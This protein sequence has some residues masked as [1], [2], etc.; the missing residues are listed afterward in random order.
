VES[1]TCSFDSTQINVHSRASRWVQSPFVSESESQYGHHKY[2]NETE[3]NR[4]TDLHNYRYWQALIGSWSMAV[5]ENML[6]RKWYETEI[7]LRHY[8]NFIINFPLQEVNV[9]VNKPC[10]GGFVAWAKRSHDK[11][12]TIQFILECITVFYFSFNSNL[13]HLRFSKRFWG[14]S[15]IQ[16]CDVKQKMGATSSYKTFVRTCQYTQCHIQKESIE[17]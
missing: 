17:S 9:L 12:K 10:V 6:Y 14:N 3:C 7:N 16:G 5:K 11:S 1:C 13:G 2:Q 15:S 4:Y 8:Y